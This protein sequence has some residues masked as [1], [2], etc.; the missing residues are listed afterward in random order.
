MKFTPGGPGSVSFDGLTSQ[1][2]LKVPFNHLFCRISP[3]PSSLC[4]ATIRETKTII[5]IL[6]DALHLAWPLSKS[7]SDS[8]PGSYPRSPDSDIQVHEE[9]AASLGH[10]G[11]PSIL[12]M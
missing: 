11:N 2:Q 7:L 12:V 9:H 3:E 5:L 6:F 4:P 8:H 1:E 10:A